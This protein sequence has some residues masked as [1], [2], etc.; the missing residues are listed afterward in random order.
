MVFRRLLGTALLTFS[1]SAT[2]AVAAE[3]NIMFI[4]DGSNS[5]WGQIDGVAKIATV[6]SVLRETVTDLPETVAPS[7]II[8]GHRSSGNCQDIELVAPFG[9]GTRNEIVKALGEISPRGKTPIAAS[10]KIASQTFA[11]FEDSSNSILL[12]S[13]GG[14]NCSGDPCAVAG[15]LSAG[16]AAVNIHVI[17]FNVSDRTRS[18][19]QC[20]AEKGKG[21]YYDARNAAEFEDAVAKVQ[22]AAREPAQQPEPKPAPEPVISDV[23]A[24]E[25]EG[26][27][28]AGVW[29][30][31][32]PDPEK[33]IVEDGRLLLVADGRGG[34]FASEN[35][36][37]VIRLSGVKLPETDWTATMIVDFRLQ[38][39][40]EVL[41]LSLLEAP[42]KHVTASLSAAGDRYYGWVLNLNL[43]MQAG[44]RQIR[45]EYPIASLECTLCGS[46][47]RVQDFAASLQM[48]A[49]LRLIKEGWT[50]RAQARLAGSDRPWTS[51]ERIT[52]LSAT[53]DLVISLDQY[54]PVEGESHAKIDRIRIEAAK[55]VEEATR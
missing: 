35:Q 13:D 55:P 44:S 36:S 17:G 9:S 11:G 51:T 14:D 32:S 26:T 30:V 2:G 31:D 33:F 42:D 34:P 48:P 3:S 5:M 53:G 24:D 46:D 43:T 39:A 28:L 18:E 52:A 16:Q 6:Q 45:S 23:F 25:F 15:E 7:L 37:N 40:R 22:I 8:H 49:E 47:Q 4:I 50:Y 1:V 21:G 12:I 10:L 20:I 41:S 29:Q 54:A 38:T 27:S 19:L